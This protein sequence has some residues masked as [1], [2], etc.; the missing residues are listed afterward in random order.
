MSYLEVGNLVPNVSIPTVPHLISPR[1]KSFFS[2]KYI[3]VE[4]QIIGFK[5]SLT[6]PYR[7]LN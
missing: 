1:P 2:K 4:F 7:V 6:V 5:L 3:I